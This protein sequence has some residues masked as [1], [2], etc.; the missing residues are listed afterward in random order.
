MLE[1]E[2]VIMSLARVGLVNVHYAAEP[3][4]KK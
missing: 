1:V 3:F 4:A 2:R